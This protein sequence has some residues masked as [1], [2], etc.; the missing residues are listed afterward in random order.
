MRSHHQGN[1]SNFLAESSHKASHTPLRN[2]LY[3]LFDIY[4]DFYYFQPNPY[5]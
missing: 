3:V 1:G 5:E 2:R 4:L